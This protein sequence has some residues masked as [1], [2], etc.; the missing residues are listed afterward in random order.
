MFGEIVLYQ[1]M[2]RDVVY[3]KHDSEAYSVWGF[4]DDGAEPIDGAETYE[5]ALKIMRE[6]VERKGEDLDPVETSAPHSTL[7]LEMIAEGE[8][9]DEW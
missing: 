8:E 9:P 5:D 2:G 4:G 7:T 1:V 6:E 3:I